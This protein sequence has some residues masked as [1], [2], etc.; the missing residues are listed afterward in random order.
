MKFGLVVSPPFPDIERAVKIAESAEKSN[1]DSVVIPDHTLMVPPGYTPNTF[2]L[3]S[4]IATKTHK[5][6]LGTG[7]TDFA[8]HHPSTLAQF[9]ATLENF[10]G[11][12]IFLGVGAGEAMN[13]KPFGIEW[14]KPLRTLKEG[15][16]VVKK[17]WSGERF[18]YNGEIFKL[19]DAFLQVKPN[20]EI[21]IYLGAN[22]KK[23][24]ILC[25]MLCNGWMPIA[26]TPKTYRENLK[27]VKKGA[28]KAGRSLDEIDTALQIYTAIDED[29]E[30]A[31]QRA[32]IFSGVVVSSLEKAEQAGYSFDFAVSK[33]FY[34]EELLV[35][36]DL[37]ARFIQ[38]SAKV[39][40]EMI[41]DFFIVGTP[42]DAEQKIE[43]FKKAGVK[44][45]MLINIGPDP[46]FVL[47]IYSEK[48]VP[49]FR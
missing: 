15:I 49:S 14:R 16:E 12:R 29:R 5:I 37:L 38:M 42:R 24:R 30:K 43:E 26:E 31:L 11:P 2:F 25:G 46:K 21:P 34:F 35:K 41:E 32:K 23:S 45:L 47:K 4:L 48:V 6:S 39:T 22:S 33:K 3:L 1:F 28:E 36:E 13:I 19:E 8:R 10:A 20:S 7:V 44:H 17:L 18:N 40:D 27:D 9:F